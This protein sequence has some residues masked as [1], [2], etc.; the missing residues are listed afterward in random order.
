MS[1][2]PPAMRSTRPIMRRALLAALLMSCLPMAPAKAENFDL[3]GYSVIWE[4][5]Y[6]RGGLGA[7]YGWLKTKAGLY[8][9]HN[10]DIFAFDNHFYKTSRQGTIIGRN[11]GKGARNIFL[12]SETHEVERKGNLLRLTIRQKSLLSGGFVTTY[13]VDIDSPSECRVRAFKIEGSSLANAK[14][15]TGSCRIAEGK[16]DF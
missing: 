14:F 6:K 9:A 7:Y 16:Q 1:A 4:G 13:I 11:G 5:A 12:R 2:R 3:T 10:G 8:F 15:R